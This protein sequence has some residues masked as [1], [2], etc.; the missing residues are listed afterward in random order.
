[1][2]ILV[3]LGLII[4]A[5]YMVRNAV[6]VWRDP[7]RARAEADGWDKLGKRGAWAVTR[8]IVPVAA[9][10]SCL[11]LMAISLIG[12]DAWATGRGPLETAGTVFFL[13]MLACWLVIVSVAAFNRPR[14]LVPPYLR[15]KRRL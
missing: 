5:A 2:G 13:L 6:M 15:D 1:M 10:F 9:M 12:A 14:S 4:L 8:G 7:H 11:A 3:C